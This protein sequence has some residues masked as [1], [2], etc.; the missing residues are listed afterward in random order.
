M[1][2]KLTGEGREADPPVVTLAYLDADV[3]SD[4]AAHAL[5]QL[6]QP[7]QFRLPPEQLGTFYKTENSEDTKETLKQVIVANFGDGSTY[8]QSKQKLNLQSKQKLNYV[9]NENLFQIDGGT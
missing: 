8:L 5:D 9:Q 7:V 4:A 6:Q 2:F 3:R 1:R